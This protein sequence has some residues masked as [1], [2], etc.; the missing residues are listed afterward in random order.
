[1]VGMAV[2]AKAMTAK[3]MM[4]EVMVDSSVH[5]V[6]DVGGRIALG[7]VGVDG[8]RRIVDGN[9]VARR[10]DNDVVDFPIRIGVE[11]E[12]SLDVEAADVLRHNI[13]LS[14]LHPRMY[15]LLPSYESW[16]RQTPIPRPIISTST[17][18]YSYTKSSKMRQLRRIVR[19]R[20][21]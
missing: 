4:A 6:H 16:A 1:V 5:I 9:V 8:I 12:N 19:H 7:G 20:A 15:D 14:H 18:T 3:V 21:H 10:M 2:M 13:P 17:K 11:G